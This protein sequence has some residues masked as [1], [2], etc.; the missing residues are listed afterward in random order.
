MILGGSGHPLVIDVGAIWGI[1]CFSALPGLA[2]VYHSLTFTEFERVNGQ[3][4][5]HSRRLSL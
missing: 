1:R 2:R 4:R 3:H 5:F